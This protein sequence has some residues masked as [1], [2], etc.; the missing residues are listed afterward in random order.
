MKILKHLFLLL[1][2]LIQS[3]TTNTSQDVENCDVSEIYKNNTSQG[4]LNLYQLISIFKLSFED[5]EI[6]FKEIGFTR[7]TKKHNEIGCE[8][9]HFYSPKMKN[10][11]SSEIFIGF[12]RDYHK[13][14][15]SFTAEDKEI[16]PEVIEQAKACGFFVQNNND[17]ISTGSKD[18]LIVTFYHKGHTADIGYPNTENIIMLKRNR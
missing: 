15:W 14:E 4:E 3:C 2:L 5:M 16:I 1:F 10:S 17:Q 11:E 8:E 18:G 9:Y 13:T 12:C 6:L 7:G